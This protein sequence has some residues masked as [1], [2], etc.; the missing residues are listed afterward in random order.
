[1]PVVTPSHRRVRAGTAC[2][3]LLLTSVDSDDRVDPRRA[4]KLDA[5]IQH[6]SSSGRPCLLRIERKAG[7]GGAGMVRTSVQRGADEI[8]FLVSRLGA[9]ARRP[10]RTERA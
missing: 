1:M 2:P 8:A 7:H 6:A 10:A 9:T 3:A 5:A 4:R